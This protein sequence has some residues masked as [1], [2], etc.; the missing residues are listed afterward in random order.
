MVASDRWHAVVRFVR[1]LRR[2][3][4]GSN[5][6]ALQRRG[7][8]LDSLVVRDATPE[9]IPALAALHATTWAETHRVR[10]PPTRQ[11]REQQWRDRFAVVDGSWFCLVVANRQG[12]LVG[13]AEARH[14]SS[15]DLPGYA[16]QLSKIYF[17]RDYQRLGLGRRLVAAV[18]Q[19]FLE[20]GITSMVLFSTPQ[21]PSCAFFEALRGERLF[22]PNGEFHGGYGW[23]DL[24]RLGDR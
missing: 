17:R 10:H 22:A 2:P 3:T 16:G 9:D 18:V 5:L 20:S 13:F 1:G 4:T 12:E 7:E 15:G 24:R 23:R 6:G 11:L 14:Y 19:R 8:T 21:N